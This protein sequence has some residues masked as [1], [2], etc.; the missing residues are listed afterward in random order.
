M[1]S[2]R[3]CV[4]SE[5]QLGPFEALLPLK[6]R[7]VEHP[8]FALSTSG[9]MSLAQWKISL[10]SFY[11][12]VENFPKFM[13]LCV[14]KARPDE[15]GAEEEAKSWLISNLKVE[16]RHAKWW[17][18]WL[19]GFTGCDERDLHGIELDPECEAI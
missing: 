4:R 5:S 15:N 13:A 1:S 9:G 18:D 16:E 7:I 6:Q 11:S 3:V 2:T 17:R 8:L 19:V 14:A 12:L 10:T